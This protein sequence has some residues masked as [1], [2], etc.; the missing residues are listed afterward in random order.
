[1]ALMTT[2]TVAMTRMHGTY[3][4]KLAVG[5]MPGS[6]TY[7]DGPNTKL[8]KP[9][10]ISQLLRG[11]SG[12]GD[13]R[14][15]RSLSRLLQAERRKGAKW[16]GPYDHSTLSLSFFVSFSPLPLSLSLSLPYR[17]GRTHHL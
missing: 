16:V 5:G 10:N 11:V 15:W 4:F 7:V 13:K 3:S 2:T 6:T 14:W 17:R 8:D 12:V 1:M 9:L